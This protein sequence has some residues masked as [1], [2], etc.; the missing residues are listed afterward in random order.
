LCPG[1]WEISQ[2][3]KKKKFWASVKTGVWVLRAHINAGVH[4]GSFVIP[5][6]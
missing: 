5:V 1:V 4:G 6:L 3:N 2:F